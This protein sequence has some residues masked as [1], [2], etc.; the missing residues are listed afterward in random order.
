MKLKIALTVFMLALAAPVFAQE[1]E[2]KLI[3]EVIARVNSSPIMRSAFESAQ[4]EVLD[5]MKSQ[6]LKPE[7]LEKKLAEWK[8]RI[9]DQLI[10]TQLLVQRASDLSI[11]VDPQV[12]EQLLRIMK[13]NNIQSLEDLEQK[14][15]EVG[16]DINEVKANLRSNFARQAVLN[17][18]VYGKIFFGLTEKD[19]RDFYEK[20][21]QAFATPGEVTLSHIFIAVGKDADAALK[22]AQEAQTQA[23][24]AADFGALAQRLSEDAPTAAKKGAIGT[25]KLSELAPEVREAVEKL[26]EGEV[27]AP[28]KIG[29]GYSIFRVNARKEAVARPFEDREVQEAV[30]Q[31]LTGERSE[32]QIDTYLAKLRNDAFIEIDPRYQFTDSKVKSASIKHT[33]YADDSEKKK[34]K[35]D[36]KDKDKKD[37]AATAKANNTEK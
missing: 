27:S 16:V 15:R 30:G 32:K 28:V 2:A 8:P 7:E 6:G 17:R 37:A 5:Q 19:K 3:D 1:G 13:E 34:Q 24:T 23:S 33:P 10:D 21:K 29:N 14:M 26:K 22:R 35:K 25:L 36:K 18:E 11:N 31:N 12:N 4:R 9:L 20:N